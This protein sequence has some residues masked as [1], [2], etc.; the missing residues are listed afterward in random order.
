MLEYFKSIR[1]SGF[2]SGAIALFSGPPGTGKTKAAYRVAKEMNTDLFR[3]DLSA[4]I[5]KYIGET[6]K[7]LS[8]VLKSAIAKNAILFLDEA[9][10]MLGKRSE[11]TDSHDRFANI[12]TDYLLQ[13][14]EEYPGIVILTTNYKKPLDETLEQK[15]QFFVKFEK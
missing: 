3:V 6:E 13:R 7:N 12:D 4:V 5:S 1:K 8:K 15:L 11:T 10:V 9:D 14:L 2:K